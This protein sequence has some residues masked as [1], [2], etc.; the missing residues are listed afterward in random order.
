VY[1]LINISGHRINKIG[2]NEPEQQIGVNTYITTEFF[3]LAGF[4]LPPFFAN[5]FNIVNNTN[6][7]AGNSALFLS[8]QLLSYNN[9]GDCFYN[10]ALNPFDTTT[11]VF[12]AQRPGL[13]DVTVDLFGKFLII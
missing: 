1:W 10:G 5:P 8:N 4:I 11:S 7:A 12:T 6:G 2:F 13:Y 9:D 3:T